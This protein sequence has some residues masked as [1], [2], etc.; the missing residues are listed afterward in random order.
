MVRS[1]TAGLCMAFFSALVFFFAST[2]MAANISHYSDILSD[3]TPGDASN[4]TIG[5]TILSD[6]SPGGYI[7]VT[8]PAGFTILSTSTFGVRNVEMLVNGTA[9]TATGSPNATYDG[10]SITTG[11]P[12]LIRYTLNSTTGLTEDDEVVIKIGNHTSGSLGLVVTYS[13]TTGTTT[14]AA[15]VEPIVNSSSLGRHDVSVRVYDGGQIANAEPV[16]F[17][18]NEVTLGPVDT[19][20]EIPPY[21]FNPAPTSTVG[22]T[23]LSVE[24]SLET[25]EFAICRYSTVAD[26]TYSSMAN[27]F[28]GTG[29]IVHTT[30]VAVTQGSLN[31]FYIR[32]IDDEGNFNTD[33]FL[34]QFAVNDQPTGTANDE[35]DVSGDGTGQGNDGTGTGAGG[36]GQTGSADGIAPQSGG[37]SGGGGSGGGSSGSRGEETGNTSG[38]GFE[39]N[40]DAYQS[41][42]GRVVITGYA[43]PNS[44]IVAL[45]DGNIAETDTSSSA[46]VYEI[47]LDEI[48]RGVYTF[49]VYGVDPNGTLSSTFSTSFTVTGARETTL[50]NVNVMPSIEV[51]P[52][53]VDIGETVTFS[54]YSLPSATITI[55]NM[56]DGSRQ[57]L[58]E[59]TTTSNSNGKWTL[60]ES[61]DGFSRGTYKVRAQAVQDGGVSTAF[62]GYTFYGVGEDVASD[63]NA[64]LNRDGSVNLIDFSIL[65]FWWQ[66]DGGDSNPPADINQDGTVSL[67]DFSILLFQWTG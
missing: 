48:A 18:V 38:G 35:G 46:G 36:G 22:G 59:F 28:T 66:T 61:T 41:G 45:V 13:S 20:E 44:T 29:L 63:I 65:L 37:S 9:R 15:D 12:G 67:T 54:G 47:V 1:V 24:I 55:E 31:T 53:P 27:T 62:S 3:S 7:D 30:V 43:F 32:C 16:V 6:V 17:L 39:I 2:A 34:I 21:R 25:D 64:D 19:T 57:S 14:T 26:T 49:G 23:T 51:T 11:T 52:D 60:S 56:K 4:H 33:D 58:K 40:P 42:D 50:S 8:P 5:F 10:V